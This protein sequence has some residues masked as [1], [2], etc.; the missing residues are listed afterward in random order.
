MDQPSVDPSDE[1]C[2]CIW[3][4]YIEDSARIFE[5]CNTIYE[6]DINMYTP[7][8]I[9]CLSIPGFLPTTFNVW[10][11][12]G[13]TPHATCHWNIGES[14]AMDAPCASRRIP[15]VENC[16]APRFTAQKEEAELPL[17]TRE[18]RYYVSR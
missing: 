5:V 3:C 2:Q 7:A 8:S 4:G 15:P 12:S 11:R 9:G 6:C 10:N 17:L 16:F 18:L 14:C 13:D 1:L